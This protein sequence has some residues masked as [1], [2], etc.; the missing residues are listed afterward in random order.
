MG[1]DIVYEKIMDYLL[2]KGYPI[3]KHGSVTMVKCPKCGKEPYSAQKIPNV[4]KVNCFKCGKFTVVDFVRVIE[5]EYKDKSEEDIIKYLRDLF[6]IKV[7]TEEEQIEITQAFDLYEKNKFSLVPITPNGKAPV[8][9]D[10]INKT[11]YDKREWQDWL[12]NHLNVGLNCGEVSGVTV[13]DIDEKLPDEIMKLFNPTMNQNTTRGQHFIYKYESDLP[14]TNKVGKYQIDI[15][16]NRHQIVI[17]PSKVNNVQRKLNVEPINKM[18]V[19]LKQFLLSNIKIEPKKE[20]QK[21]ELNKDIQDAIARGKMK[22]KDLSGVCN[23]T[24][25][26]LGGILRKRLSAKDTSFVLELMNYGLLDDP[27]DTKAIN[28]MCSQIEKYSNQDDNTLKNAIVDYLHDAEFGRA[29]EIEIGVFTERPKGENKKKFAKALVD[30]IKERKIIRKGNEYHIRKQTEWYTEFVSASRPLDIKVPYFDPVAYFH[31][32]EM[33]LLGGIK[34][35][36]KSHMVMN[37]VKGISEQGKLVHLVELEPAKKFI[38]IG[39]TLGL[40]EGDYVYSSINPCDVEIPRNSIVVL[41]WI[42]PRNYAETDKMFYD[43]NQKLL[44]SNSFII[45]FMQIRKD[46]TWFAPDLV[47]FFPSVTARF[48]LDD[49]RTQRDTSKLIIDKANDPKYP[50]IWEIPLMFNKDTCELTSLLEVQK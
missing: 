26:K 49:Y 4:S 31:Y 50:R 15:A 41:D 6:Q 48:L 1:F 29:A 38:K 10:W 5:P 12:S 13:V 2:L 46:G 7:I 28:A 43:F 47:E 24:F 27:M 8:E 20:A 35:S 16:N 23:N 39:M 18:S 9:K 42:L 34:G 14:T 19:E 3:K 32:G 36:G 11:H 37:I 17:F 44:E 30:L 40:K 45:A 22:L 25:I 21:E 33:L